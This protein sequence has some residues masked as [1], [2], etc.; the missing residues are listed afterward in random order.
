V[1]KVFPVYVLV[2]DKAAPQVTRSDPGDD[3]HGHIITKAQPDGQMLAQFVHESMPEFADIL[4]NFIPERQIVDE[5]GLSGRF[6][7]ALTVPTAAVGGG[8]GPGTDDG[9][10]VNA[11][12]RA[13]QSL[14]FKLVPK[15]EPLQVLVVDRLEQPSAN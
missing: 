9:D 15:K 6:N 7:F 1:E 5:T 3:S 12:F 11:F 4:M 14:G 10:P 2:V 8:N 13:V